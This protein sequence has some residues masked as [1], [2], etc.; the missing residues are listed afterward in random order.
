MDLALNNLQSWY[1]IK[2]NK[3]NQTNLYFHNVSYKY[4]HIDYKSE[5]IMNC[6]QVTNFITFFY[7]LA[8]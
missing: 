1:A 3:P 2:P 7:L 5:Y 6:C 4:I 8:N